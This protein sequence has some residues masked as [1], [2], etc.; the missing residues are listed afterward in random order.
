M[1]Q[2]AAGRSVV[3]LRGSGC[4][5]SRLRSRVDVRDLEGSVR[6]GDV[7]LFSSKHAAAAVTKCFTASSWD[8]CGLVIKFGPRHVYILEYAG[9]V[10]LYPL[11]TRLYTY[12]AI[13]GREIHL[14]RLIP[15]QDREQ[16]QRK[17]EEFVRG[18]LGQSP[19]SIQEMVVAVL[20][21]ERFISSFIAHLAGGA[22][23]AG[24]DGQPAVEDDL[25]TLF[26]SKLI[27][28]VYKDAGLLAPHRASSDFLPKHFSAAYDGYLDLQ[29]GA[30]LGPELPINFDSVRGEIDTIK[31][32]L[33]ESARFEPEHVVRAV[34]NFYLSATSNVASGLDGAR[35]ALGDSFGGLASL[36]DSLSEAFAR[37]ERGLHGYSAEADLA[38]QK[39]IARQQQMQGE[40]PPQPP[41][42]SSG[43]DAGGGVAAAPPPGSPGGIELSGGGI[44]S[45][46]LDLHDGG[47]YAPSAGGGGGAAGGE[48]AESS[49]L[50]REEA[51][52]PLLGLP[53]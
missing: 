16:M 8:H 1:E 43:V 45:Q 46:V 32:A 14:R 44:V 51:N 6:T 21:Q 18:V 31:A 50:P 4:A 22:G 41:R 33:A 23:G 10:Y 42:R 47:T 39:A 5:Q 28:A 40:A 3:R 53:I 52:T 13:Q 34:A 35:G 11:F 20:K 49:P 17:V 25:Q 48:G 37:L 15:G 27:A 30:M 12:F 26:C 36:G 24:D 29:N 9:G 7:V 2:P 38:M 19:P